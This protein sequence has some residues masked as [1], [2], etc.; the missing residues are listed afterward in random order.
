MFILSSVCSIDKW[1]DGACVCV[2]V[3]VFSICVRDLYTYNHCHL[4]FYAQAQG[5]GCVRDDWL[6]CLDISPLISFVSS[7]FISSLLTDN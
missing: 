2:F 5:S 3:L 7:V 1:R 4:S 6:K